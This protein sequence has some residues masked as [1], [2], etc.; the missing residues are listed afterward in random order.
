MVNSVHKQAIPLSAFEGQDTVI[1]IGKS[2]GDIAEA[3]SFPQH[4]NW[5][6]VQ[7]HPEVLAGLGDSKQQALWAKFLE[8]A[9]AYFLTKEAVIT[10]ENA[11]E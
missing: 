11:D 5:L 8:D 6:A 2:L 1:P 3:V 9:R 7:W 10:K 4:P